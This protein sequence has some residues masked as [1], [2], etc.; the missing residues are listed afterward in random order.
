ML[1]IHYTY[2]EHCLNAHKNSNLLIYR[3][4]YLG[5]AKIAR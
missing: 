1:D 2:S 4:K 5:K 3:I